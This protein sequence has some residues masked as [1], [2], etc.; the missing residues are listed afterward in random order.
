MVP[1]SVVSVMEVASAMMGSPVTTARAQRNA[2]RVEE[3]AKG[4]ARVDA[5]TPA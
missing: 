1:G 4:R 2:G 3:V 5:N